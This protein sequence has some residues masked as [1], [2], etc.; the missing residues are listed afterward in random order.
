MKLPFEF[1]DTLERRV[2]DLAAEGVPCIPVLGLTRIG[3]GG[4][5]TTS[6]EHVHRECIEISYCWRGELVF[7]SAG[8]TY[9]F[10]PGYV[11]VS[12]PDEPHRLSMFPKGMF[13]YWLFFRLPKQG[14][15]MLSMSRRET[16]W[17]TEALLNMPRRLFVGGDHVRHAFQRV[18]AAYDKE[19]PGTC[20]RAVRIR[21]AVTDLLLA[22][23]DASAH[24]EEQPQDDRI[25]QIIDEIRANPVKRISVDELSS[26]TSISPGNL[27]NRFKRL[28]GLPPYAF[29]NACRIA[30]AKRELERGVVPVTVLA[31]R[32]GYS[33]AQN[34]A[35]QFR[36]AT[37]K[38]PRTWRQMS[39]KGP[40]RTGRA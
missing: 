1:C 15:T 8:Q 23:L 12:R 7:E 39:Q 17:F 28:A 38:T 19:A 33:S 11:F 31:R 4:L 36:L 37:G 24:G 21:A 6:E 29:R 25:R 14:Q 20:R 34:F 16:R 5:T 32:L 40:R 3:K 30:L 35:T 2:I 22:V 10:R 13:M 26:R 9:P 27:N 18:F